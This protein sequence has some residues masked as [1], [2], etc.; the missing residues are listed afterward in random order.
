M[1]R[2]YCSVAK[3]PHRVQM[4]LCVQDNE[5][6]AFQAL[7]QAAKVHILVCPKQHIV[8]TSHLRNTQEDKDLCELCPSAWPVGVGRG[9]GADLTGPFRGTS[10]S[11]PGHSLLSLLYFK[12]AKILEWVP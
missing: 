2:E 7:N 5:V 4:P 3:V 11:F 12:A 8:S 9:L 10:S 1:K 6:V